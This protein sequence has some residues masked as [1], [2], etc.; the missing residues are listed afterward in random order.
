MKQLMLFLF[1]TLSFQVVAQE[2]T[3]RALVEDGKHWTYV[4]VKSGKSLHLNKASGVT[5]KN[6]F[7]VEQGATLTI[8]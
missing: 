4:T 8:I 7:T 1:V 3:Y 6:G 2:S 5:I